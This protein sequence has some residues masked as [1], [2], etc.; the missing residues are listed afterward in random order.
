MSLLTNPYGI[1]R[2]R[3]SGQSRAVTTCLAERRGTRIRGVSVKKQ[4]SEAASDAALVI[5]VQRT[6]LASLQGGGSSVAENGPS[7]NERYFVFPLKRTVLHQFAFL[8]EIYLILHN[9]FIFA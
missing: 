2:D 8:L 1:E 5:V 4:R 6:V 3:F 9:L 7:E